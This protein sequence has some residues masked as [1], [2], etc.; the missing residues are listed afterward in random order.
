[1]K[2]NYWFVIYLI[3]FFPLAFTAGWFFLLPGLVFALIFGVEWRGNQSESKPENP[4]E[5]KNRSG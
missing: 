3:M 1:M 5:Q 4:V 2:V